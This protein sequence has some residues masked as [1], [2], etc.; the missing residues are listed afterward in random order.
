MESSASRGMHAARRMSKAIRSV[1]IVTD[2]S[3]LNVPTD[4]EREVLRIFAEGLTYDEIGEL[5]NNSPFGSAVYNIQ[6]VLGFK[7]VRQLTELTGTGLETLGSTL[8]R[9]ATS[10]ENST[11]GPRIPVSFLGTAFR[12]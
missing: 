6:K 7:T 4:L 10:L 2:P 8:Q 3:Q 12:Q 11:H 9:S 1:S 5:R